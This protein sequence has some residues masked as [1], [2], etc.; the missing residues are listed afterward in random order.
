MLNIDKDVV[1]RLSL[2]LLADGSNI[3]IYICINIL[4][5][6]KSNFFGEKFGNVY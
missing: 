6:G 3:Y 2:L 4:E 5:G 1:N